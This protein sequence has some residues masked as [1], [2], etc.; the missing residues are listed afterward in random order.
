MWVVASLNIRT[1][2]RYSGTEK[3]FT[4]FDVAMDYLLHSF[5]KEGDDA[6]FSY[7]FNDDGSFK[8]IIVKDR[9]ESEDGY[10]L[11]NIENYA[12]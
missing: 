1:N 3:P 10:I 4:A 6:V 5:N 7:V 12:N 11:M 9:F 2:T 8:H